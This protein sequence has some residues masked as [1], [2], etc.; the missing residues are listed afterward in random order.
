MLCDKISVSLLPQR[1]QVVL[2]AEHPIFF[3]W[4]LWKHLDRVRNVQLIDYQPVYVYFL[5]IIGYSNFYQ[6]F[7]IRFCTSSR[8]CDT[9]CYL[10]QSLCLLLAILA[11][12][13]SVPVYSYPTTCSLRFAYC[14]RLEMNQLEMIYETSSAITRQPSKSRSRWKCCRNN[15]FCQWIYA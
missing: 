2:I 3:L 1:G 10:A 7:G 6:L 8:T 9:L 12:D 5:G 15:I 4:T 11:L 14:E 13:L